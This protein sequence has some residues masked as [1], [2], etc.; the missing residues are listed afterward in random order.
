VLVNSIFEK[1]WVTLRPVRITETQRT[2][3]IWAL[4][5]SL[6]CCWFALRTYSCICCRLHLKQ[7][8][9]PVM[10]LTQG[11]TKKYPPYRDP[12]THT[13]QM[14]VNYANSAGILVSISY[15]VC[16]CMWAIFYLMQCKCLSLLNYYSSLLG[17]WCNRKQTWKQWP[18]TF[19]R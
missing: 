8:K 13:M 14:A 1:Y 18:I 16:V 5:I 11:V 4:L 7:N 9:Y 2:W 17:Q 3:P 19:T 15:W 12:R 10:F 6:L